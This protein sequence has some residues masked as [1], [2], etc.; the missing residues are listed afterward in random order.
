MYDYDSLGKYAEAFECVLTAVDDMISEYVNTALGGF[1][2]KTKEDGSPE[3]D[4]D[5]FER[6]M[7]NIAAVSGKAELLKNLFYNGY[8]ALSAKDGNDEGANES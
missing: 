3:F 6:I 7:L 5:R 2:I 1:E 4:Q 8:K